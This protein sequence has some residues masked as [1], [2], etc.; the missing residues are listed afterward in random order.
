M[1]D[2]IIPSNKPID[3]LRLQV[4]AM[5]KHD[6]AEKH[7]IPTGFNVSASVNRNLGLHEA[8]KT[9]NEFVIM[10]D[11]DIGGFYT[12]WQKDLCAPLEDP[13]VR[14]TSARLINADGT[15]SP[16]QGTPEDL[17]QSVLYLPA[18]NV[19]G[20]RFPIVLSAAIAF[21]KKDVIDM[22]FNM[23]FIGSGYEDTYF[24]WELFNR[25]PDMQIVVNNDCKLI[26]YHEMKN[27]NPNNAYNE[28]VFKELIA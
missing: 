20:K 11:D 9:E 1:Y 12:G 24:C 10:I 7:Y 15:L 17:T 26:H 6:I 28:K 2:I 4:A 14:L 23:Q 27:Q 21:R 3:L 5:R 16:M 13:T 18:C 22:A 25:Y 8:R 19:F